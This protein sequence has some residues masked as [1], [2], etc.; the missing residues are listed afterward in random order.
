MFPSA[1]V[2]RILV[3]ETIAPLPRDGRRLDDP[4]SVAVTEGAEGL[5]IAR[6]AAPEPEVRTLHHGDG[7]EPLH[8]Q[9]GHEIGGGGSGHR[10]AELEHDEALHPGGREPLRLE[11][12]AGDGL[13]S[14]V[15]TK[16]AGGMRI[17]SHRDT[18][19]AASLRL[20]PGELQPH[21]VTPM[22]SVK[23]ADRDDGRPRQR[24]GNRPGLGAAGKLAEALDLHRPSACERSMYAIR[25]W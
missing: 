11:R 16:Q 13:R 2:R 12:E 20:L 8:E 3:E 7:S 6:A 23:V 21:P 14:A 5:E 18:L 17:E 10:F 9:P 25:S 15:G 22:D 4:E 24:A 19:G 1:S